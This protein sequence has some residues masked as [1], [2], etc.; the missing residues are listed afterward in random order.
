ML[1]SILAESRCVL[2]CF[3]LFFGLSVLA[4]AQPTYP[5]AMHAAIRFPMTPLT[6]SCTLWFG[7]FTVP[8]VAVFGAHLRVYVSTRHLHEHVI[9]TVYMF[10]IIWNKS[11]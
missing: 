11:I 3:L 7:E 6:L 8:R 5:V 4:Q 9:N 10:Y 2:F 1:S